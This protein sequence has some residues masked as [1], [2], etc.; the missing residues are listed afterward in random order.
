MS[1]NER[2]PL[3]QEDNSF[4]DEEDKESTSR[5]RSKNHA[6]R[7]SRRKFEADKV[8][9]SRV[10][11]GSL[12]NF[13]KS[14][15][16]SFVCVNFIIMVSL[17][18]LL[19][20]LILMQIIRGRESE[21]N[22]SID[23]CTDSGCVL[24]AANLLNS[25]D[26]SVDPCHN[27]YEYA[28]GTW[29][30]NNPIPDDRSGYG[31][32]AAVDERVKEQLRLLLEDRTDENRTANSI[33]F[34][35]L[36]F[37]ECMDKDSINSLK[38]KPLQNFLLSVG[39]WPVLNRTWD[40]NFMDL[41]TLSSLT[42]QKFGEDSLASL[43]V[44]VDTKNV[45]NYILSIDQMKLIL[46]ESTRDYYLNDTAY[47]KQMKAYKETFFDIVRLI[48]ADMNV[49]IS[50]EEIADNWKNLIS[51]EK[52]LANITVPE[53]ERRNLTLLYN[54]MSLENFSGLFNVINW[55]KY[56]QYCMPVE[57]FDRLVKGKL[58]DFQL[59]VTQPVYFEKLNALL[60]STDKKTLV[61]YILWRLIRRKTLLLDQRFWDADQKFKAVFVGRKAIPN[62]WKLCVDVA[63]EVEMASGALYIRKYFSVKD[64][65][66][67][68]DMIVNLK[69]AFKAIVY[70]LD[71][72][73]D[74]TRN[75]AIEKADYMT[76]LVGYPDFAL[77]DT[78]LDNYYKNLSFNPQSSF[79]NLFVDLAIWS[80]NREFF[81]LLEA[82]DRNKFSTNPATVNAFN[83]LSRNVIVFP[84]G[85]LQPPFFHHDYPKY[86]NYA[87]MGAIIGHELTHGFD[88]KG[89]Q[90]GKIGSLENWWQP[91]VE[92]KFR[93]K[94]QCIQKQYGNF[95][96]PLTKKNV[97]GILTLG[98][99]IADN[100]GVKQA[101]KAYKNY[102]KKRKE[103]ERR[104]PG[105]NLTNEQTFF[106]SYALFWCSNTKPATLLLQILTDPHSPGIFRVNG[107]LSNIQ[108]FASA[109]NCPAGSPM[110]PQD[111][112][113]VW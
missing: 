80:Q 55:E 108:D 60:T 20:I 22:N 83:S 49:S 92:E 10:R 43:G 29:K 25:I 95:V 94:T 76:D 34:T 27:F 54:K 36:L 91:S 107:P 4:S 14:R 21:T 16:R 8:H 46:G 68:H 12:I 52:K 112:C 5:G 24:S 69:E 19:A 61:N 58:T 51:F 13:G 59:I 42:V 56:L 53:E 6:N 44:S 77:N 40:E 71:W 100:G 113:A 110:N 35:K 11:L 109:Y 99:N 105:L 82:Y 63:K 67:A 103:P 84:A 2:W 90:F 81:H 104:L 33:R 86:V 57:V 64:K 85:I 28:C 48:G 70:E 106:A 101:L 26:F 65:Q 32:F 41:T 62:R 39:G 66:E 73:D 3:V 75:R 97:N 74:V 47:E 7:S 31:S 17:F 98:E 72:M 102:I 87:S 79:F 78:T 30:K 18:V 111:K 15:N 89:S 1:S 45:T 38:S 37:R 96:E 9:S 93:S 23:F 50:D 88:D